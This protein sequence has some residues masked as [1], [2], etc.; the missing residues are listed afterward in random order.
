MKDFKTLWL[1][2]NLNT[3]VG[4]KK[5]S[6]LQ[7][8]GRKPRVVWEMALCNGMLLFHPARG[9][10]LS[11]SHSSSLYNPSLML[12]VQ[13]WTSADSLSSWS[14]CFES[15]SRVVLVSQCLEQWPHQN[16]RESVPSNPD[17]SEPGFSRDLCHSV[18]QQLP[19]LVSL[20]C[21]ILIE[22]EVSVSLSLRLVPKT[23]HW[24][25]WLVI[26]TFPGNLMSI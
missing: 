6:A 20:W 9:L 3:W 23:A 21:W 7:S 19:Y 22:C 17:Q 5:S 15:L 11:C 4:S 8:R 16:G 26:S 12:G 13:L 25:L 14:L 2:S 24:I 18:F 10:Q 1:Q